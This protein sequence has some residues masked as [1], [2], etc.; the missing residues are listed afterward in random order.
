M[1]NIAYILKQN[2]EQ[3]VGRKLDERPIQQGNK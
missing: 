1:K 3:Q 2:P